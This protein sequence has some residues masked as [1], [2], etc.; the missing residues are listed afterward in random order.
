MVL[1]SSGKL[2]HY[3]KL[4]L[5]LRDQAC[6]RRFLEVEELGIVVGRGNAGGEVFSDLS[7]TNPSLLR[8]RLVIVR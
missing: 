5:P 1:I 8:H 7:A 6:E 4:D 3:R 2:T